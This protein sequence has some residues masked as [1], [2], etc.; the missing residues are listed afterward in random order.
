MPWCGLLG[1]L[2]LSSCASV[3]LRVPL[4]ST[5]RV[6][7]AYSEYLHGLMKDAVGEN[8]QALSHYERVQRWDDASAAPHVRAGLDYLR[9]KKIP[10]AIRAFDKGVRLD[11]DDENARFVL[12][13]LYVQRQEYDSAVRH[14]EYLLAGN[15]ENKA[16]HLKLRRILSQL[17]FLMGRDEE[18]RAH[19]A[20]GMLLNPLDPEILFFKAVMDSDAGRQDEAIE[21]LRQVLESIP[22]HTDA[23]NSLAYAYAQKGENLVEA[24]ALAEDAVQANP[25]S[26]AYLDTLGWVHFR[27]GQI[28]E[29]IGF[30][31]RAAK[32]MIEPEILNHLAEAYREAGR[33]EEARAT[34]RR[35]LALDPDQD[36]VRQA[37]KET[38]QR[39]HGH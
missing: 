38:T 35:S 23:M 18:A 26:G 28:E 19:I 5:R 37:L 14:Y 8:A 7:A 4:A 25:F 24:L 17:N 36:D 21:S 31:E 2:L 12:A 13:L 1:C 9:L 34:W 30:L 39:P 32:L 27:L 6:G 29:A 3:P 11:P 16:L 15:L 20:E 33:L 10:Q 22:R